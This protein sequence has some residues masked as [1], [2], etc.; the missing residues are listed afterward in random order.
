M[1]F[2]DTH[3]HLDD[4]LAKGLLPAQMEAA[5]MAGV[6][7]VALPNCDITTLEAVLAVAEAYPSVV[8]PMCGLHPTYVGPDADAQLAAL[9]SAAFDTANGWVAIGEIGLDLYWKQDNLTQQQDALEQQCRWALALGLPV[10]L[11]SRSAFAQ[12]LEVVQ[13]FQGR[14]R[15][16]FHCF[17][18]SPDEARQAIELGFYLGIGGNVTYKNN[19]T[20]E[21]LRHIGLEQVVLETDSPYLA[22]VPHRGKPNQPAYVA[23]VGQFLAEHLGLPLETVASITTRNA[24]TLFALPHHGASNP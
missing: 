8:W 10:V 20:L 19:P 15:G 21:T 22:P 6:R 17:T 12:T 11:H 13:G 7:G 16:V 4:A 24:H 3:A 9:Q 1:Q 5:R 23:L 18:G 14:L 2:F